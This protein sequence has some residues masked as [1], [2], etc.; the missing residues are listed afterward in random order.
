REH[1]GKGIEGM[2]GGKSVA[3]GQATWLSSAGPLPH[4]AAGLRQRIAVDGSAAVFVA[5]DGIMEGALVIADPVRADTPETLRA[6]RLA[7]IDR[8]V[9]LSGDR[10]DV[11][12]AVGGS[13][14]AD[15][16]LSEHT[17]AQK[18]QAVMNE[19]ARGVTVMVG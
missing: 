1:A 15:V 2:V 7:G 12:Q 3:L 9:L 10:S 11:A 19:R 14:G 5:V 6:L 17:P 8:I 13:L 16:V 18:V 4:A